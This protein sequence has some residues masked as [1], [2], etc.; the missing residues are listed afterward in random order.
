MWVYLGHKDLA[1]KHNIVLSFKSLE[2]NVQD[3]N[4]FHHI[5]I[6]NAVDVIQFI[7]T[8]SWVLEGFINEG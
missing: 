7:K 2:C 3:N 8:R 6:E 1:P 5:I 4:L